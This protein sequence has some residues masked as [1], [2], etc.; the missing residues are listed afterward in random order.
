[1]PALAGQQVEYFVN[2][3]TEYKTGVR[4]NDI[5]GRMRL[6]SEQLSEEDIRQL[7]QYYY[8]LN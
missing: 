7:A 4:H 3:L 1:M 5:Y 2:T 8:Q 6:I